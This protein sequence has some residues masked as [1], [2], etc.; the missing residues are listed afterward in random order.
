[1]SGDD[2]RHGDEDTANPVKPTL[3]RAARRVQDALEAAGLPC[4]VVE[5]PASTRTARDAA[6]AIGCRVEEIAKTVVFRRQDRDEAVVV[7]A[8]G[9]SRVDEARVGSAVGAPVRQAE[10][11]FVREA[12]GYAI[13]GVPPLGHEQPLLTLVDAA[14]M[15]YELVWAAAGTPNAVFA[16]TPRQL[17]DAAGG[18]VADLARR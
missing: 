8:S 6:A 13:G 3:A 4:R 7:I 2:P 14:L 18:T 17:V 10:P 1:V 16:L 15:V 9:G 5:L 12:T 11:D